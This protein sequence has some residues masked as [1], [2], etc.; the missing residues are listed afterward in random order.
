MGNYLA[1]PK[2]D[3]ETA[4]G[5]GPGVR[6]GSTGMQGW[7]V[8]M[9][10]AHVTLPDLG[11]YLS[12]IGMYAVFD[13][14]GGREVA[15]F[16]EKHM[17]RELLTL[18]QQSQ[19]LFAALR[20]VFPRIDDML[21]QHE[22]HEEL[23]SY[24][25][26]DSE[27]PG[28]PQVPVEDL[29][30]SIKDDM[31]VARSRGALTK[32][33]AEGI[34]MKMMMLQRVNATQSTD[35]ANAVGCAAVVV[36]VTPNKIICANAGDSRAVLC[37][38]G[39]PIALSIDHK[40]NLETETRR[41]E[42]AGG[43]VQTVKRG[44]FTTYRVNGNLSLSRAIGDLQYKCHRQLPPEKQMV[45]SVPEIVQ[46]PRHADDEFV[47]IACDGIWDVKSSSEVCNFLRK[48]LM[49]EMSLELAM[50]QLLEACCT[51]DPKRSM[52]L[53]ADNM[54]LIVVLFNQ[55]DPDGKASP[56]WTSCACTVT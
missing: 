11:S 37:R 7:R 30:N 29:Q 56:S 13:G 36:L 31:A 18:A 47:V 16:C 55:W 54:T 38:R 9:E 50:E 14:H 5:S 27:G 42:A 12:G 43:T 3:K 40:P 51:S 20:T 53:G 46:H 19:D 6:W 8:S 28:A 49:R 24:R 48:R 26:Q 45:T 4:T 41:I 2:K 34:L 22:Y 17:P 25:N 23:L 32:E 1:E 10:D 33:D 52:G 15:A 44:N 39:R 35:L 21:R